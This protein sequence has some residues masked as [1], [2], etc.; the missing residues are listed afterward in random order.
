MLLW[1]HNIL[2]ICLYSFLIILLLLGCL[3]LSFCFFRILFVE[4]L[5]LRFCFLQYLFWFFC[6]PCL[7]SIWWIMVVLRLVCIL[8]L[9]YHFLFSQYIFIFLVHI[10]NFLHF[11]SFQWFFWWFFW[12]LSD[13]L[14]LIFLLLVLFSQILFGM[15][16]QLL[17]V[18][19]LH[20]ISHPFLV[21]F[22]MRSLEFLQEAN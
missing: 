20:L 11:Q 7:Q 6:I 19:T 8:L 9:I 3:L 5:F 13:N 18:E 12:Y 17:V 1:N 22:C 15:V 14:F 4:H 2:H 21:L 10:L 16:Q